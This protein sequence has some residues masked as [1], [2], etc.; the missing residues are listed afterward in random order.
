MVACTVI[1]RIA[2]YT[3][4]LYVRCLTCLRIVVSLPY[5]QLLSQV[6]DQSNAKIIL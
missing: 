4:L 6:N 5:R 3:S 2:W 1:V